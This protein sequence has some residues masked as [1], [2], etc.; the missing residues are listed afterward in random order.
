MTPA[1]VHYYF[2]SKQ[3]LYQAMLARA[4]ARILERVRAPVPTDDALAQ[5]LDVLFTTVAAEPWI[6]TL[7]LREVLSEQGQF[8]DRFVEG[9]ASH[10][11]TLVPSIIAQQKQAGTFRDD[12]D[13]VL[14]FLSLIGMALMPFIGRPVVKR[15]LG[16]D[17]D[18]RFVRR[19]SDH[20]L[21]LFVEGAHA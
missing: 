8:R 5:L 18:E 15:V 10:M 11:A 19:F 13:P 6:P 9:Y 7:V 17:Y 1:M 21:R 16:I 12:L 14:S 20:T 4:F 3:G 2:G